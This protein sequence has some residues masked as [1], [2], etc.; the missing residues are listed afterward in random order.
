MEYSQKFM[1][2]KKNQSTKIQVKKLKN[3]KEQARKTT[4]FLPH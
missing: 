4:H 3:V 2:S 1:N